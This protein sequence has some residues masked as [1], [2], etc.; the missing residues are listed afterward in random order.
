VSSE[1]QNETKPAVSQNVLYGL[2]MVG[3][4]GL[5]L[6][7]VAAGIGVLNL[8]DVDS[9]LV[10]LFVVLGLGLLIA[11]IGGWVIAT[12]PFENFDD[13]TVAQ[14]HGHH[15]EEHH[16]EAHEDAPAEAASH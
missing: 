12:R 2:A 10:G 9:S 16:E 15:H 6:M 11:S 14:Y 4:L 5:T 7:I 13:I 1:S 8:E 3:G